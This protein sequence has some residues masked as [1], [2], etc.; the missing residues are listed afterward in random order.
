MDMDKNNIQQEIAIV[1]QMIEK[2]RRE[3][4]ESGNFFIVIGLM[5]S[6]LPLAMTML[7]RYDSKLVMPVLILFAVI[8]GFAGYL[9]LSKEEKKEKVKTYAKA[10]NEKL[11]VVC[12]M[13]CI[14]ISILFPM[15]NAFPYSAVPI[16]VSLLGGIMVFQT[17]TI[18]ELRFI[19]WFGGVWW[20]GACVMAV[21]PLGMPRTFIM[22]TIILAGWVVPGL[23]LKMKYKTRGA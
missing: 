1:R 23:L 18:Y 3:T 13:A 7:A 22:T 2:S 15:I 12:G 5:C 21:A 17:G 8:C 19:Q 16:L 20:V 10:I 4:A 9:V 6:V 14:M 11:W